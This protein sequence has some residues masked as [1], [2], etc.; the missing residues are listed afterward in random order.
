MEKKR[1]CQKEE[2]KDPGPLELP[3]AGGL[4]KSSSQ[5]PLSSPTPPCA[6][7]GSLP[8][9]CRPPPACPP[10]LSSGQCV[11]VAQADQCCA[12]ARASLRAAL[13]PAS[14]PGWSWTPPLIQ[15][16]QTV[17]HQQPES[18]L[19]S[20]RVPF[21]RSIGGPGSSLPILTRG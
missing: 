18:V 19:L 7:S 14:H 9:G 1:K 8:V 21:S 12:G 5:R 20:P 13:K 6:V 15:M 10:G 16:A 2:G 3:G 11:A 4:G 17:P